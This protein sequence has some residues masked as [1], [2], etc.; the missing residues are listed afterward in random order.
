MFHILIIKPK[1]AKFKKDA[2]AL[3][4]MD[5][6]IRVKYSNLLQKTETAKGQGKNPIW[7]AVLTFQITPEQY[8]AANTEELTF[9]AFDEDSPTTS[10]FLGRVTYK[11]SQI[12]AK[13][14]E[15]VTL[16]LVND[17][18]KQIG[19]VDVEIELRL[20]FPRLIGTVIVRPAEGK[21]EVPKMKKQNLCLTFLHNGIVCQTNIDDGP[22]GKLVF[23]TPII[24]QLYE[25]QQM[26]VRCMENKTKKPA[27]LGEGQIQLST[28]SKQGNIPNLPLTLLSGGKKVS[29][30]NIELEFLSEIFETP[31]KI[32]P[33]LTVN[34]GQSLHKKLKYSNPD[35]MKKTL[36]IKTQNKNVILIKTEALVLAPN[37]TAEIKFEVLAPGKKVTEDKCRVD[38]FVEETQ[39]VEETLFFQIKAI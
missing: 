7:N 25:G 12:K 20:P 19:T 38:I 18:N 36:K 10:E 6:F 34:K 23:Q 26:T 3:S 8:N 24:F 33:V 4:K 37:E 35:H 15:T 1:S 14:S 21:F 9:E 17:K 13:L 39:L 31:V 16:Q 27:T 2:D 32:Y 28:L 5:P 11:L 29:E 30:L 22:N